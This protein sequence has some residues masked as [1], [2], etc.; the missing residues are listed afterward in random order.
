MI[1]LEASP[2]RFQGPNAWHRAR[3]IEVLLLP[4]MSSPPRR[5][6]TGYFFFLAIA[7]RLAT[8][9][10]RSG[11]S[12]CRDLGRLCF[13]VKPGEMAYG[14]YVFL[15]LLRH[16]YDQARYRLVLTRSSSSQV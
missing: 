8:I 2:S 1:G 6:V 15:G 5:N 4:E 12:D 16:H 10:V 9:T 14:G 7:T 3:S 13:G 11:M